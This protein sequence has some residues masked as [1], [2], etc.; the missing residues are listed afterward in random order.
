MKEGNALEAR[1]YALDA[2][3]QKRDERIGNR[4]SGSVPSDV[5]GLCSVQET[6]V[7]VRTATTNPNFGRLEIGKHAQNKKQR[8]KRCYCIQFAVFAFNR[9]CKEKNDAKNKI[10]PLAT[11]FPT[12]KERGGS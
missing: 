3:E 1:L 2:A 4:V 8:I 11:A 7:C 6:Q 5:M 9:V 12:K 10:L